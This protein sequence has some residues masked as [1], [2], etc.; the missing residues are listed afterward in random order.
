M[1]TVE[2]LKLS[3]TLSSDFG[4]LAPRGL[5]RY[6]P[7]VRTPEAPSSPFRMQGL[8]LLVPDGKTVVIL[9][10]SGC[11]KSTLL[12][13]IGGLLEPDSGT[14]RYD[15]IDVRDV[16]PSQRQ[17]GMVFQNYALYPH[18]SAKRNILSFFE[19][20]KRTPALDAEAEK[21]FR[22]T[23]ELLGVD[24]EHLLGRRPGSLS[25]GE[26][27][28]VAM[29]RCITRDPRLFLLDEPFSNLD[30]KLRE[31]YRVHL[32]MLLRRFSI[33]TIYVTHD[34]QEA[35]LLAD[36]VAV[37]NA[38]RIEQVGPPEQVYRE[39]RNLFVAEFLS[40]DSRHVAINLLDG[41]AVDP[42]YRQFIVGIR[43]E[44]VERGE[45]RTMLRGRVLDVWHHP[46][47]KTSV[48]TVAVGNQSLQTS[49]PLD[50]TISVG[51]E[52]SLVVNRHHLFDR[53]TGERVRTIGDGHQAA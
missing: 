25:G 11:G 9:G 35:L 43:P 19:F 30:Q 27:Q 32:K 17:I 40:F 5:F 29:G 38:G 26:R 20:R 14:V 52:M 23:S 8:D 10:P 12:R 41:D 3:K 42:A 7:R 4:Q 13:L 16:P 24:I 53:S 45:G 6:I 15:G 31:T 22:R 2:C 48:L 28:R 37:M 39:P 33:T 49:L 36:F 18:F 46:L 1:A 51:G 47:K 21:K 50:E 34:Q 44:E